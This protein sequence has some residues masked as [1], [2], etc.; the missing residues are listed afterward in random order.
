MRFVLKLII[1]Q[2]CC[3]NTTFIIFNKGSLIHLFIQ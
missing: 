1:G 2:F 3:L